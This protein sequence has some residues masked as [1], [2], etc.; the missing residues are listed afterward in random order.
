M[1]PWTILAAIA[2]LLAARTMFDWL[3]VI[4]SGVPTGYG[5]GAVA[6]AG[7][8]LARGGDPYAPVAA[9][10]FVSANYP[11]LAYTIAALGQA[12][13]PFTALRIANVVAA[14]AV[15]ALAAWRARSAPAVAVALGASFV[16][17]YP[18]AAWTSG[19]RVDPL[20]VALAGIAIAVASREPRRAA[21]AGALGA[22]AI[23][24]K[25]TA[26]V[27]LVVVLVYLAWRERTTAIRV[28]AAFTVAFAAVAALCLARFE[29]RGLWEHL[30]VYNSFPYDLRNP[31]FLVL[32]ALLLMG[33]YLVTAL[34]FADGRMRA[35]L[36]GALGVVA[37]GGHEGATINYLLD[38]AAAS[39]IALAPLALSRPPIVAALFTG[40]LVATAILMSPIGPLAPP[41][42]AVDRARVEAARSLAA[43]AVYAEDSGP[44]VAAGVEPVVDDAYVWARL[45]ALGMRADDVT[46]RV[47][48]GGFVAI[49][50]DVPLDRMA[51]ANLIERQ[52]WPEQLVAAVLE[53]YRLDRHDSTL[54][55][56]VPR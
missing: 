51:E 52:R 56:Y 39:C 29:A 10:T 35:Y 25:P 8:I 50:S 17:L 15:A 38:L 18:V 49:L 48:E 45:V 55:M 41:S 19:A 20:A 40:H 47:R 32:L 26:A 16:A 53:R 54:W 1:R 2:A 28:A 24:A 12:L 34:R 4:V 33:A 22:L 13:G 30:V 42:L 7:Q 43:G 36:V 14:L 9:G 11:P 27:P 46:P 31:V 23:A 3:A 5:E 6:H 21:L 37:L 44:L